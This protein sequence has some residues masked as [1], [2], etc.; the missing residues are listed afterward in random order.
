MRMA[1]EVEDFMVP[2]GDA[3]IAL[4]VR[5]RRPADPRQRSAEK[6]LLYVHGTS[7]AAEATFDLALD[8]V[9]WMD[10]VAGHGWDVYLVDLRGYGRS[11]RPP[12]MAAPAADHAPIVTTDV[13]LRDFATAAAFARQRSGAT[14]LSIMGWSW[15]TVIVGAYAASHDEAVSRLVLNAP[16][17]LRDKRPADAQPLGAYQTWTVE[18]ALAN[19]QTG[20]PEAKRA[21]LMPAPWFAA[22]KAAALATDPEGARRDPPVVRSPNGAPHDSRAYWA[23]GRTYYDPAA[24]AAPTLIVHGEWDGLLPLSMAEAIFARLERAPVKRLVEIGEGTHLL[25]LERNRLQ[26][27]RE[28]QLFLDEEF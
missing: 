27:F 17:W 19:L 24:I 3:G 20:A 15:G 23:S 12:E 21:G 2:S 28:V 25:M 13:A 6:V 9:S 10:Y 14:R 5:N 7:Q 18:Q 11:T 4:F 16:V 1:T 22:W 26:L 8:G